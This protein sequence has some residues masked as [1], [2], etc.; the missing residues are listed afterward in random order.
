MSNPIRVFVIDDHL[1]VRQGIT[2]L[3]FLEKSIEVVGQAASAKEALEQVDKLVPDVILMDLKMPGIDGIQLTR[4]I[5][6]RQPKCKIIMLTLYDQFVAEATRAGARGYLLKDITLEDLVGAIT[7]VHAGEEVFDKRVKPAL[8]VDYIESDKKELIPPDKQLNQEMPTDNTLYEQ[9]RLFILPP[10]D[11]SKSLRLTSVAE[12]ALIG[13]FK[14]VEGT[15]ADGIS[16]T[17]KLT[18]SI[19]SREINRR[20]SK[21]PDIIMVDYND[22]AKDNAFNYLVTKQKTF[23]AKHPSVKTIFIQSLA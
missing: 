19:S 23:D 4:M 5:A 13:D 22:L 10:A 15:L 21:I 9:A 2:S 16:I 11:I 18:T 20:I 3:L 8:Q 17:F 1:L 14:Q 6:D 7:R 12:E